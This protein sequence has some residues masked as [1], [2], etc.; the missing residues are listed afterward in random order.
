MLFAP[1]HLTDVLVS[2]QE[3]DDRLPLYRAVLILDWKRGRTNVRRAVP[4]EN[5]LPVAVDV[6]LQR[7]HDGLEELLRQR[8]LLPEAE[9]SLLA[10]QVDSLA[11]LE[12]E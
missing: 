5:L 7:R 8:T 1:A 3:Q 10:V 12:V 11:V 4:S 6:D 2:V 9:K